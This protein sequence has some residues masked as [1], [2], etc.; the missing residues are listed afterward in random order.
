MNQLAAVETYLRGLQ[1]RICAALSARRWRADFARGRLAARPK[2]A[3]AARACSR[4]ARVFEQAGV[5]FSD[6][7]GA[8]L[9]PAATA[10]RPELAG[11]TLARARRV[12]GGA[13]AQSA[14]ADQPR[15]RAL[16]RGA[17]AG[18]RADLVVRRRL[19]PD[20]VLSGRRGR[21]ALAPHRARPVRAVRRRRATPSTRPGATAISSSSTATRRAASA[22]C[23]ST[24][25]TRT[26]SSAASPTSARS[27][28]ASSMPT[29]RS[30]QRATRHA[31]RRARARVPAV[32]ARPLRRVQ[33]G[34]GPRHAVRPAVGRSH[35]EHPDEPAAAGALRIRLRAG[36]GQRRGAP[37]RITCSRA[38]G[39]RRLPS[40][41]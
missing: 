29:C 17:A 39:W 30:S 32:P 8:S 22:A 10:H 33:P 25:S 4:T 9:P 2:A 31:L 14:R 1:D 24:T 21:A 27:A 34:L 40:A 13:S 26:A 35:R 36:A 18:R 19:R 5:G 6:V 16:L 7:S 15:Q 12:A 3:A 37:W 20:A 41:Q 28:T 11:A 23:S 38:T